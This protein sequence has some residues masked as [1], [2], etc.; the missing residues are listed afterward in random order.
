MASVRFDRPYDRK[1]AL[2]VQT[3]AA[4]LWEAEWRTDAGRYVGVSLVLVAPDGTPA[5][6]P[7]CVRV[8]APR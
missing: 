5:A 7:A 3:D 4:T 6:G 1:P 2:D 8:D